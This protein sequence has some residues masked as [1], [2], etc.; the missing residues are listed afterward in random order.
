MGFNPQ[1]TRKPDSHLNEWLKENLLSDGDIHYPISR[2]EDLE[3]FLDKR[4][5]H[6]RVA[7]DKLAANQDKLSPTKTAGFK[8]PKAGD[9]VL[10]RDFQQ[11]KDKGRKLN[12]RWS[13]LR[14]VER[15]SKSGVSAHVRQLHEPPGMTKRYHFDDLLVYIPRSNDYP[16]A[17][18]SQDHNNAVA[19]ERGAFGKASVSWQ[20]GQRSF[21][22]EDLQ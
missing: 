8:A 3:G 17:V 7:T 9:L 15:V 1:T 4:E 12:P 6:R 14:L 2:R 18:I 10:L 19:Y 16:S 5:E 20:V 13:T 11:A 22:M 21:N